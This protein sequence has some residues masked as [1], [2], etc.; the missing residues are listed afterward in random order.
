MLYYVYNIDSKGD[1]I[2]IT[3][4][5]D[6]LVTIMDEM[7]NGATNIY[8]I[9]YKALADKVANETTI[10]VQYAFGMEKRRVKLLKDMGFN[11]IET[12][13]YNCEAPYSKIKQVWGK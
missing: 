10:T 7:P 5:M 2:M 6:K 13:Y 4:S 3:V 11:L 9:P 1:G 8:T 12:I